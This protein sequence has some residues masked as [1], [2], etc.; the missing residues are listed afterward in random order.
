MRYCNQKSI[1]TPLFLTGFLTIAA[2]LDGTAAEASS[3]KGLVV[4]HADGSVATQSEIV[5]AGAAKRRLQMV[6]YDFGLPH[7]APVRQWLEDDT[8]PICHTRWEQDGI[9]YTQ[10]VLVT[11]LEAAELLPAGKTAADA[12]L[13]V[14]LF[15]ENFTNAYAEAKADLSVLIGGRKKHLELQ[16]G[17][18]CLTEPDATG[19]VAVID[20]PQPVSSAPTDCS[21]GFTGTCLP[22]IREA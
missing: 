17:L 16:D 19:L 21:S 4:V 20:C 6:R 8:L 9:R 11:R 12:V 5:A 13:M 14:Q 22:A 10:T 15:G 3:S 7:H 18:A 1:A 2:G